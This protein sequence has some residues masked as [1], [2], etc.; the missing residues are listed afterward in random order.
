MQNS[1]FARCAKSEDKLT[2]VNAG[3]WFGKA[4]ILYTGSERFVVEADNESDALDMFVDSER[5]ADSLSFD[6]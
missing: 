4:F 1:I 5:H 6:I 2:V 3:E